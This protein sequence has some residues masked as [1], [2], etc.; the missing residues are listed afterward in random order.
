M[1]LLPPPRERRSVCRE[2]ERER[3]RREGASDRVVGRGRRGARERKRAK[4]R[5]ERVE[6]SPPTA[7]RMTDHT[8]L[9]EEYTAISLLST[10]YLPSYPHPP[11]SLKSLPRTDL[12]CPTQPIPSVC[13]ALHTRKHALPDTTARDSNAGRFSVEQ[14]GFL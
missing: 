9:C 11:P 7:Q 1:V 5:E 13:S 3:E 8:P 4:S 6:E 12:T 14:I 10:I 2:G